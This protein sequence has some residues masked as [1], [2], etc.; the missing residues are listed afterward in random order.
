MKESLFPA[1][2]PEG[3]TPGEGQEDTTGGVWMRASVPEEFLREVVDTLTEFMRGNP[4][5]EDAKRGY[6][7]P[8]R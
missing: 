6:V 7:P 2:F 4:E 5:T 3:D 1:P 8:E